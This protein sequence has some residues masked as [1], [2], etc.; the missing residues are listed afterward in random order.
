MIAYKQTTDVS[1]HQVQ[2]LTIDYTNCAN[3]A[4]NTTFGT[5]PSSRVSSSFRSAN[6]SSN[7]GYQWM[8]RTEAVPY[9]VS[10]TYTV[11]TTVCQL[12]FDIPTNIG[13][14]V[15]FYYRLTKFYQN[16]RRYVKSLNQ[17]QINGK[18]VSNSTISSSDCSPLTLNASGFAY[19]PCGLIANSVFNDTFQSPVLLTV[20]GSSASNQT[21]LMHTNG[22]AWNSDGSVFGVTAYT[23]DQVAPPPNWHM[24]YPQGY[25]ADFPIPNLHLDQGL[26][27]WMRTSGLPT[28]SKLALR[29]DTKAMSSGRYQVD[30]YDCKFC[31]C[32][33]RISLIRY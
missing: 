22:T 5:L 10:G 26:Q 28:F 20:A 13:P 32:Y 14:P 11:D 15:L 18:F 27:T 12:Q 1:A 4:P 7:L 31:P 19:Y 23:A 3:A 21:Y 6:Y 8:H 9:G 16:H 2:E 30:I 25:N 33:V 24:R 17:D 29:N